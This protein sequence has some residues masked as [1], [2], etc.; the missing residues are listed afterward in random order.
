MKF[1][2]WK[3]RSALILILMFLIFISGQFIIYNRYKNKQ[4]FDLFSDGGIQ[5]VKI[6]DNSVVLSSICQLNFEGNYEI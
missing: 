1:F 6:D 5:T 4:S 3:I 2:D